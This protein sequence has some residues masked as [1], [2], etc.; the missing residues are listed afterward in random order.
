MATSDRAEQQVFCMVCKKI[1]PISKAG[2]LLKTAYYLN[3]ISMAMSCT[4][5]SH[6]VSQ[7]K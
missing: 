7:K 4:D 3:N 2:T 1:I 5:C 6:E